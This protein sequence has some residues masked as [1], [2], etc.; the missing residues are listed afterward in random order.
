[1]ETVK[2]SGEFE[3]TMRGWPIAFVGKTILCP[4]ATRRVVIKSVHLGPLCYAW[5]S[6]D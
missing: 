1:M 6:R 2:L 4:K 3:Q 5:I